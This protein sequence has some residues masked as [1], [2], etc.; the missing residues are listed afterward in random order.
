MIHFDFD[1]PA[2]IF[3]GEK[4]ILLHPI[5]ESLGIFIAMRFYYLFKKKSS[6]NIPYTTS[7]IVLLGATIGAIVGSKFIGNLEKPSVL[8]GQPFDIVRFW[9]NNTIVGGLAFGLIGVELA[10]KII[11]HK[12]STGDLMVLPLIIAMCIGRVGCFFMGV[13]EE[14][15]GIVTQQPWGMD[16]GD[17]VKRHPVALYE[18]AFLT[19]LGIGLYPVIKN[20]R[21]KNGFAFQLFMLFYFIFRFM[22]DF[23]KPH[24]T[25]WLQLSTIQITCLLV[26][27][28]Y[29]YKVYNSLK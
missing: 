22:L 23:I 25:L 7:L 12:E 24:E 8:I 28:Y 11:G 21:Y 19:I 1:F 9:T 10:K 29:I 6:Y 16:L 3:I 13:Y 17:G 5:L 2:K 15:Y 26:V 27:M 20:N 14:T 4:A 18:I